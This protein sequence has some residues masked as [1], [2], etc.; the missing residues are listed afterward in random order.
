MPTDSLFILASGAKPTEDR[1][2]PPP[3]LLVYRRN[4]SQETGLEGFHQATTLRLAAPL[5]IFW[6]SD[7]RLQDGTR[8]ELRSV[9]NSTCMY[10]RAVTW[11]SLVS[12]WGDNPALWDSQ[13]TV[14]SSS[15]HCCSRWKWNKMKMAYD[16]I[17][18]CQ[19]CVRIQAQSGKAAS[20]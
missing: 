11:C 5:P 9:V 2:S 13:N 17:L 1:V 8:A 7:W 10:L 3:H 12:R 20:V 19:F 15:S 6:S 18:L 16:Y 14:H 4:S